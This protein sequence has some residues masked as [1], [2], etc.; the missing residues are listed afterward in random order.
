M[1][2][3]LKKV[4]I[5]AI[6]VIM[7]L[8]IAIGFFGVYAKNKGVWF[9]V[10]PEYNLGMEL[11]GYEELHFELDS[12]EETKNVYVDENGN[13][14]GD[15]IDDKTGN[16]TDANIAKELDVDG[17]YKIEN[18]TI[19]KN[20]QS[21]INIE[22]FEKAKKIIQNRLEK[23]DSYEYN[24]R[25]DSV[26]GKIVLEL[27][28][29]ADL[30]LKLSLVTTIGKISFVDSKTG[31]I[32]LDDTNLKMASP[33]T[34]TNENGEYEVYLQL[35]FDE[36]GK[37]IL[38][39]VTGK[40]VPTVDA[41]GNTE[42]PYVEVRLDDQPMISTH[43]QEAIDSG[44]VH[45]PMGNV[46]TDITEYNELFES[47]SEVASLINEE[48][49]PLYYVLTDE[50][51]VQ[52]KITNNEKMIATVVYIALTVVVSLY[53][54]IKYKFEGLRQAILSIGYVAM[55]LIV[56]RYT[57]VLVTYNSLIALVGV[58]V[59]NYI[60]AIKLLNKL[61]TEEN[62]SVALKETLKELYL[63]I[64]PMCIIS[65][66]FTFMSSAIINSVGTTIFWGLLIQLLFSLIT[67][68]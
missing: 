46:T 66:I 29:D 28:D 21:N 59:V 56:F 25:Q 57:N 39:E 26:T 68:V 13:Y 36:K 11:A 6:L 64:I 5:I 37:E 63:T 61:N 4:R 2:K 44:T 55:L 23:Y 8:V 20:E 12:T 67:L 32:L 51:S 54:I 3:M 30:D 10:L 49:L 9:N 14:K 41:E 38:K 43:F 17:K 27:P 65:V 60:F 7:L 15:V 48:N 50:V 31:L 45:V 42:T 19:R 34:R 1:E 52:S 33:Y 16:A 22:N 35:D 53:M 58:I 62:R 40:Y 24:I 47:V 18:K